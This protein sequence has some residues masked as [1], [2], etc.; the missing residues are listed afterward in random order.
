MLSNALADNSGSRCG[1]K[2]A[3]IQ[4]NDDVIVAPSAVK[5]VAQESSCPGFG[6]C[7]NAYAAQDDKSWPIIAVTVSILC[8]GFLSAI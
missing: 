4:N 5:V 7:I 1:L 8:L 2:L 6:M 3:E